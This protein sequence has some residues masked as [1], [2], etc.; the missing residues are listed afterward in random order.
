MRRFALCMAMLGLGSWMMAGCTA[1]DKS[2]PGDAARDPAGDDDDTAWTI[3]SGGP[4]DHTGG[5]AGAGAG[6]QCGTYEGEALQ[7]GSRA[8]RHGNTVPLLYF[9][10]FASG[11]G[12]QSICSL[13]LQPGLA[14]SLDRDS[15]I[16]VTTSGSFSDRSCSSKG[17]SKTSNSQVPLI[18]R[19]GGGIG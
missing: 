6:K 12:G 15:T 4:Q 16:R 7:E 19:S 3:D 5:G 9:S 11:S 8:P 17:S 2:V 10:G 18:R 14:E 1:E 13:Q